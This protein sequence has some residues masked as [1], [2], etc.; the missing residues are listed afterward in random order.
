M[1]FPLFINAQLSQNANRA[2]KT[3]PNL[4]PG[5]GEKTGRQCQ[6]PDSDVY[7]MVPRLVGGEWR[8]R[9]GREFEMTRSISKTRNQEGGQVM[10][11]RGTFLIGASL[12]LLLA[13]GAATL[14]DTYFE[15]RTLEDW[16]MAPG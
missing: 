12:A 15:Y 7:A 8:P 2:T 3:K 14:A 6:E 9:P 4:R 16:D 11:K 13:G 10:S 5:D 1:V